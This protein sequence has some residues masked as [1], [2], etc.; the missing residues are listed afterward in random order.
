MV[1]EQQGQEKQSSKTSPSIGHAGQ[2]KRGADDEARWAAPIETTGSLKEA[3][4]LERDVRRRHLYH[5]E[6]GAFLRKLHGVLVFS[7]IFFGSLAV[8][9]ASQILK[10]IF[11]LVISEEILGLIAFMAGA[12]DVVYAPANRSAE[13]RIAAFR[14]LDVLSAAERLDGECVDE[15][16][17]N[18]YDFALQTIPDYTFSHALDAVCENRVSRHYGDSKGLVIPFW[19]RAMKNHFG[20]SSTIFD[21]KT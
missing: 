15:K 1:S 6:R 3:W 4:H 11:G 17:Q 5:V 16:L 20:F 8:A 13:H 2:N 10:D 18:K 14:Y 21:T 12:I 19:K 9:D 7:F